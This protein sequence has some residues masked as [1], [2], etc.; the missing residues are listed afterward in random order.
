M[1]TEELDKLKVEIQTRLAH[2]RDDID[3]SHDDLVKRID[4]IYEDQLQR[5][6]RS[7]QDRLAAIE[8]KLGEKDDDE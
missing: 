5:T 2:L 6:L 4:K 3:S 8:A 1:T 7:I